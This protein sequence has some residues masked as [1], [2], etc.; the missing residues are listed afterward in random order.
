MK[1]Y[2]K[3]VPVTGIL[4][5]LVLSAAAI[6]AVTHTA[7]VFPF[8]GRVVDTNGNGV[9]G[10]VVNN[11][12]D[13]VETDANG[14]WTLPTDT[15]VCKFVSISTPAEYQ[16]PVEKSVAKGFYARVDDIIKHANSHDFVLTRRK[17]VNDKLWYVVI[18]DP[19]MRTDSDLKRWLNETMTDMRPFV[20]SL[21]RKRE[22]VANTLGDLVWDNMPL[23]KDYI[24][25]LNGMK[26]TTF[27]C[28]GNHD[29]DKRFQDLHNMPVGTPHY[30]EQYYH[31]YFGPTNYSY[32]IGRIHVITLK[33][34]NYIG[35][36]AYVEAITGADMEWLRNDLS[37][38]PKGTTVI[39]NMH[40]AAWNTVENDGNVRQANELAKV[41]KDYNVHVF[42]GHT[43]YLQNTVVSDN[44]MEHN[45]GAACGAW[46]DRDVNRC[47]APNGYMVVDIDGDKLKWHYKSTGHSMSYQMRLYGVGQMKSQP[48]YLVANVW[49]YDEKGSVE[50]EQDGK[51]MGC[52]EQFTDVDEFY[53]ST[54]G[55]KKGLTLTPHLFRA[56]PS[57][58]AKKI[59]VIF[60][61]RF[62]EK[63]EQSL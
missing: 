52:M 31:R 38:V 27:Q 25:S 32:N 41:L 33:N 12:V 35:S 4:S 26:M 47:G 17:K 11:G 16:L 45:I 14:R 24:S 15:N 20:D 61:N 44:L 8:S 30:A 21:S 54:Q 29:F 2:F 39:L 22:V 23:F 46:W 13:F 42:A 1:R 9:K 60:T 37:Y 50:W 51:P 10:V 28:I 48:E 49:D 56:K 5:S 57:A 53:A 62:G 43:H 59:K 6:T 34:I 55:Y 40:A 7:A 58:G 18:S 36:I 63:Y 19:Q 3:I